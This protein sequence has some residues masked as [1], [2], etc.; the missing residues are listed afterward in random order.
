MD[1]NNRLPAHVQEKRPAFDWAAH[2]QLAAKQGNDVVLT[3]A[4]EVEA[5]HAKNARQRIRYAKQRAVINERDRR[6]RRFWLGFGVTVGVVFLG[7]LGWL[8]W[9]AW[10]FLSVIGLGVLAFPILLAAAGAAVFG[11]HKCITVVQ[12]WH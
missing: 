8:V 10:M 2:Q 9:M 6:V 11:G 4:E 3:T 5:W 12:H 7:V 1:R